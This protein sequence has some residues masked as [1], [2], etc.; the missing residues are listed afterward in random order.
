MSALMAMT[1]RSSL[2]IT[3]TSVVTLTPAPAIDRVHLL[4]DIALGRVNR[5][6]P[7]LSHLAGKGVNVAGSLV[8]EGHPTLMVLPWSDSGGPLP[9]H[10]RAVRVRA[11]TRVNTVLVDGAGVTTNINEQPPA[12]T[13]AEWEALCHAT[14][15]A[16]RDIKA[17]WLVIGGSFPEVEG[18]RT[19]AL[20]RMLAAVSAEGA[21]VCVDSSGPVLREILEHHGTQVDLIKPNVEELADA[22]GMP[23]ATQADLV[24]AAEKL[25]G[26][27]VSRAL[28]TAGAHGMF[29]IGSRCRLWARSG[30]V[31][32]VNTTGAGDAAL[33]G[34]LSQ[35]RSPLAPLSTVE[36]SLTQAMAW[37]ASAVQTAAAV[38]T[39]IVPL[40]HV[41]VREPDL[42][43]SLTHAEPEN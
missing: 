3:A 38:P 1:P 10:A 13:A 43:A 28:V 16:V 17:H 32:V 18:G 25:L 5:A 8:R 35:D 9:D 12:L 15:A 4:D 21:R 36:R 37:G 39:R 26:L 6:K 22:A 20:N 19:A 29:L 23:V 34:F 14:V 11:S 24:T 33:A 2:G 7:A 42:D 27:G 30:P 31:P 40:P 41:E